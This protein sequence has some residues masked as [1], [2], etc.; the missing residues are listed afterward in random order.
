MRASMACVPREAFDEARRPG[1]RAGARTNR[2]LLVIDGDGV[3]APAGVRSLP[4][5]RAKET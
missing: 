3:S 5:P 4:C 2:T 1:Q